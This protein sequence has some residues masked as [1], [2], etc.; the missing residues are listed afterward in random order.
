MVGMDFPPLV[1]ISQKTLDN[2]LKQLGFPLGHNGYIVSTKTGFNNSTCCKDYVEK[3]V[4]PFLDQKRK[5]LGLEGHRALI[6]QDS[7]SAHIYDETKK[8]LEKYSIDT[9]EFVLH[10]SHFCQP[11]D[12]GIFR[13][14]KNELS[15]GYKTSLVLSDRSAHIVKVLRAL[16]RSTGPIQN[17]SAFRHAGFDLNLE[18]EMFPLRLNS[19]FIMDNDFVP[20]P[21][22]IAMKSIRNPIR[23]G[24]MKL[25]YFSRNKEILAKQTT[26]SLSNNQQ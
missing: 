23:E 22:I 7:I 17:K 9:F 6:L 13:A 3:V 4:G 24:R 12:C 15:K 1:I 18:E 21:H 25:N 8:I 10:T 16:E 11:C 14:L 2:D 5:F 20:K 19:E 26:K